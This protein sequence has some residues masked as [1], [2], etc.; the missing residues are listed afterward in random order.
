LGSFVQIAFERPKPASGSRRT[1]WLPSAKLGSFV[2]NWLRTSKTGIRLRRTPRCPPP[3]WV[4][5]RIPQPTFGGKP[6]PCP[7][8]SICGSILALCSELA[9][10]VQNWLPSP[11]ALPV[12]LRRP[13][14]FLRSSQ[15]RAVLAFASVE[16]PVGLQPQPARPTG[17]RPV[18][19]ITPRRRRP[20]PRAYR[21]L[22]APPEFFRGACRGSGPACAAR[23]FPAP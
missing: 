10:N 8:V 22:R 2:Q 4:L 9:S 1:P 19:L 21:A 23:R 13:N 7:S 3:N 16:T 5:P 12:A 15:A 6:Y 20:S 11:D 18:A 17:N 14:G